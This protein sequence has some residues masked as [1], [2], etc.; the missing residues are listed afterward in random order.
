MKWQSA[1]TFEPVLLFE[2]FTHICH[3]GKRTPFSWYNPNDLLKAEVKHPNR[4]QTTQRHA[5]FLQSVFEP[6]FLDLL[7][8]DLLSIV[9]VIDT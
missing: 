3:C 9:V 4:S 2:R 7:F 1:L 5:A 6:V 8:L